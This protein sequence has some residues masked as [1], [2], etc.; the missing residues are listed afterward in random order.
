MVPRNERAPESDLEG[1]QAD[2]TSTIE[3]QL[4]STG[5]H[6]DGNDRPTVIVRKCRTVGQH[7][8]PRHRPPPDAPNGSSVRGTVRREASWERSS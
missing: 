1:S 8:A 7:A 6:I 4:K 3:P 5:A 2:R